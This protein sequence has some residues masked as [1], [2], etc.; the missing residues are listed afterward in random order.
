MIKE[1]LEFSE[2]VRITSR[3]MALS[4]SNDRYLRL[5]RLRQPIQDHKQ[6]KYLKELDLLS[7]IH[8]PKEE[9][10][11]ANVLSSLSKN[12]YFQKQVQDSSLDNHYLRH[13]ITKV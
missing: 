1:E 4:S 13:R 6:Q 2:E 8:K 12:E 7:K 9:S 10:T 5:C 11:R 3:M